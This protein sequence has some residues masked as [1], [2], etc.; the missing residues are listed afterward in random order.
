MQGG[1]PA[2]STWHQGAKAMQL[3]TRWIGSKPQSLAPR[4][5]ICQYC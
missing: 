3:L 1:M 2:S 5:P 4:I